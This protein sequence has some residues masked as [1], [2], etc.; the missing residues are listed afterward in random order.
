MR[1]ILFLSSCLFALGGCY[2]PTFMPSGYKYHH[3]Q[4]KSP[5]GPESPIK[6][7]H[8]D[9]DTMAQPAHSEESDENPYNP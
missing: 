9:K 4:Y 6:A 7:A 2:N 3:E 8:A 5:P 1:S